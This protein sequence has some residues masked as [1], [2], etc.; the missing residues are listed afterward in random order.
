MRIGHQVI[1]LA[2]KAALKTRLPVKPIYQVLKASRIARRPAEFLGRR[3]AARHLLDGSPWRGFIP[4]DRGYRIT[5]ART[6]PGVDA[7]VAAGRVALDR[8]ER[9]LAEMERPVKNFFANILTADDLADFPALMAFALGPP[10]I[11]SVTAYLG[12]LPRLNGL[13][14]YVSPA[15]DSQ[16][17]S[18]LFHVDFDDFSQ[19]KCFVNIDDVDADN[20]PFTFIPADRSRAIRAANGHGFRSSN[21]PDARI[22]DAERIMLT[23]PA[24]TTALVDTS[25][26]LHFGS[27]V[28]RGRRV[29]FM[30]QYTTWPLPTL[31][32]RKQ[33]LE[34][35]PIFTFP[36][37]ASAERPYLRGLLGAL[38]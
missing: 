9:R 8:H 20:G 13:G 12:M 18:Q 17:R 2:T 1:E 4:P 33:A 31:T 37:V 38:A 15:N 11:E 32:T 22:G 23:G 26:C 35:R 10:L 21:L 27:R 30:C 14:V 25:N 7:V 5:D 28:R 36:P 19:V 29:V 6:L 24:G 16:V 34:G 3:R